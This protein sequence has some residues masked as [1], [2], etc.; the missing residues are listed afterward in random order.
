MN[1]TLL[2]VRSCSR[3]CVAILEKSGYDCGYP[4]THTHF[5]MLNDT[6]IRKAKPAEKPYKLTDSNGLYIVI[7]PN[8][9]KLWRYRFRIDGKESLFS[10]GAYPEISLA[11]ARE[12]RKEARLLVQQGINPA[13]DRADRKRQNTRQNKNTFQAIAEEYFATKTISKGSIKA[14]QSMLERYAYP[15]IGDTP[16]TKVTPRQIMECLDVCKDKGVVVSG[17]YTRQHMSAVFL[18]AIRTMR[19]ETDPTLAFAGY[20]KRPEITHAKAMTVEQIKAFK[21]SLE[22]YN[23][24][25]V[26]KK[27]VQLLL[28]TA[29]RTIEA[30]R[31]EWVDID[32]QTG[33]WRIPANKMKK[34]RLHIVPLSWQVV[35][36]LKE[37]QAFTGSGRLLFPNSRRPDDMISATTINRALEY[38]GLTI[39]GHDFRATLATNLSEMGYEHEH[40]KA[41]LAHAKDNQTDAAYFHAKYI[42]QRRQMLQDWADFID[43]L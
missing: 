17:I 24:S 12:K 22:N 18:Y 8:G 11:E 5:F 19:A 13:K 21:T 28:Y 6:Q 10:I 2:L 35:E 40:I 38:M 26:V 14:A 29:V 43:S 37:L 7:N 1:L 42:T 4:L 3:Q 25:F 23:G 16:I 36:I 9:S 15:I 31:A 41:Q 27:A 30:R 32:L 33:I 34:S 20:L 39:S